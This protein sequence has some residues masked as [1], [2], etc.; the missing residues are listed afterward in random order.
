MK[1]TKRSLSLL[2]CILFLLSLLPVRALASEPEGLAEPAALTEEEPQNAEPTEAPTEDPEALAT[3]DPIEP[4][5][6]PGDTVGAEAE[7]AEEAESTAEQP[8]ERYA[9]GAQEGDAALLEQYAQKQLDSLGGAKADTILS[10]ARDPAA[11]LEGVN[12]TVYGILK[13]KITLVAS[14]ESEDMSTVFSIPVG[15]LGLSQTTW[16]REELGVDAI[17]SNGSITAEAM[18]AVA[19]RVG[20]DFPLVINCLMSACPYELYWYDKT[21]GTYLKPYKFSAYPSRISITDSMTFTFAVSPDYADGRTVTFS[22]E[23]YLCGVDRA[24][25]TRVGTAVSTAA[26]IIEDYAGASVYEKLLGYKNRICTL[27]DYDD[28]A[29]EGD[30]H[31]GD[32]WQLISVFDG[33]TSTNVVCE[34]YAKAFQY[35]CDMSELGGVMAYSVSGTMQGGTG[36]GAH[37]WNLV[38][39]DDDLVYLVDV[40]NCDVGSIGYPD[41]LFLVGCTYGSLDSYYVFTVNNQPIYYFY[42]DKTR[43]VYSEEELTVA[44]SAYVPPA[45]PRVPGVVETVDEL[46]EDIANGVTSITYN[47]TGSFL[48]DK[49]LSIPAGVQFALGE[50]T[51]VVSADVSMSIASG[52]AVTAYNAQIAGSLSVSGTFR[53]LSESTPLTVSGSLRCESGGSVYVRDLSF[54]RTGKMTSGGAYYYVE[55][56]PSTETALRSACAA[57]ADS[58]DSKLLFRIVPRASI[59][60]ST[61]LTLPKYSRVIVNAP[62]SLVPAAGVTL[63]NKGKLTVYQSFT[64]SGRVVNED[65]LTL[66]KGVV[67]DF[68]GGY[69]GGGTLRISK[70]ADDPFAQVNSPAAEV[71]NAARGSD[72][73]WELTLKSFTLCYDANGGSGSFAEQTARYGS[74]LTLTDASPVKNGY[75]FL[76]WADTPEAAEAA[77]QPGGSLTLTGDL[78]LYAVWAEDTVS[79]VCYDSVTFSGEMK[80]NFYLKL[81]DTL[82]QDENAY[83]RIHFEGADTQLFVEDARQSSVDGLLCHVFALPVMPT[84]MQEEAT[85]R[86]YHG[87]G[88]PA[89]LHL[90]DTD[91]TE[92]GYVSSV[93]AYLEK[94]RNTSEDA[95]MVAL[96]KAAEDYGAAAELYFA[97]QTEGLSVSPEVTAVTA[98]QLAAYAPAYDSPKLFG[99]A[100]HAASV[101][102]KS[103]NALRQYFTLKDGEQIEDYSFT[104]DGVSVS[105]VQSGENRWYITLPN[106]AAK[107]LDAVHEYVVSCAGES[108]SFRF[109]VLSYAR[110]VLKSSTNADMINL[111]KALYLYNQAANAY[112]E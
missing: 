75:R 101:L 84:R 65:V 20:F 104:I 15:N 28:E 93:A 16:T 59:S 54:R 107:D 89:A 97:G 90:M 62:C 106:I 18:A 63:T 98:E 60:L 22:G 34:G 108:Y 105:P 41:G 53:L 69:A 32:P 14:G 17:V 36:A 26:S 96:A 25:G 4:E 61:D 64:A 91:L 80:L 8:I 99:L 102:F 95:K 38:R 51:L 11:T 5:D 30:G 86:L 82:T 87:D 77:W 92:T 55:Q 12:R 71:F 66:A 52:A 70:Y 31:Y 76:G 10:A 39:M 100:Q 3:E 2:L 42:A 47:G 6:E 79:F 83:V 46:L 49:A 94:S 50:G 68:A 19:E 81:S 78:T 29:S 45:M 21:E 110:Q 74:E 57:A 33:N 1:N 37:M 73:Y 13:E 23:S 111:A 43:A 85:L 56:E 112:F 67:A 24:Y 109:S 40:T 7:E 44:E 35:L 9:P 103:D 88:T 27:V 48:V 72:N 58:V